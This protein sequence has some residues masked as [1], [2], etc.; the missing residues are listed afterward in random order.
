VDNAINYG[1]TTIERNL[2]PIRR[3]TVA[4]EIEF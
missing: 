3:Y 1:Y 4:L 2:E